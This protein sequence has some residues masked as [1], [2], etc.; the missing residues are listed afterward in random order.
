MRLNLINKT[1]NIN[2]LFDDFMQAQ[3]L[4][5][6][7][8]KTRLNIHTAIVEPFGMTICEAASFGV[9]SIVNSNDNIGAI[10]L[11]KENGVILSSMTNAKKLAIV[12]GFNYD[13]DAAGNVYKMLFPQI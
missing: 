6:V 2:C 9:A 5:N 12:R 11:L 7:L 4:V 13:V 3:Q 10:E 8:K 1:Q